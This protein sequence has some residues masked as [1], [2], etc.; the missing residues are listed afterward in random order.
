MGK[1]ISSKYSEIGG[2]EENEDACLVKW[3]KDKGLCALVADGLGGHGGGA[4]ASATAVETIFNRFMIDDIEEPEELNV[5]VQEANQKIL[6][7]QNP[8]CEMKTTLVALLI[9]KGVAMWGHVG[10]SRLYHFVDGQLKEY[11]FDHSV[12]QMAVLR[13]EITH[14]EIRGHVDRN[15]LI[16]ALGK[17]DTIQVETSG[18]VDLKEGEHAFLLCTDGFWEYV[19][20]YQMEETLA[21]SESPKEWMGLMRDILEENA[22]PGHDNNTA[23]AIMYRNN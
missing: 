8:E 11:T 4:V 19:D 22:D 10:D 6:S 3:V 7:L 13:G 15:R 23:V 21:M 2:R 5:W 18:L 1:I 12:S 9:K 20:E 17:G 16:R 14:E